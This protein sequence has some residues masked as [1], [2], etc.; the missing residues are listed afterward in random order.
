MKLLDLPGIGSRLRQRL[1]EHYGGEQEA[2]QAVLRGDVA[3][4][5]MVLS[6]RQA[7][8]LVQY[9]RSMKYGVEQSDFLATD[10][11]TRIYQTL[12]TRMAGYAHT[13]YAR[14]KVAALFPTASPQLL[15]ENQK[16]ARNAVEDALRIEGRGM[17]ELLS[18]I[19]PLR[20]KAPT[21]VRERAVATASPDSFQQL[22]ASGLD[23][24]IDLHLAESPRELLD[25]AASYSH[26]SLVGED[27]DCPEGM[28]LARSEEI[29]YLVPEA[30]LAFYKDNQETLQSAVEAAAMLQDAGIESFAGSDELQKLICRLDEQGDDESNR[31]SGLLDR[32]S[33]CVS[34]AASWANQELKTKIESSSITLGGMDLLGFMNRGEGMRELFEV[35]MKGAF[36]EILKR[37]RARAAGESARFQERRRSGW[38]RSSLQRSATLWSWIGGPCALLSRI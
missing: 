29:W 34:E 4:L 17:D 21:R 7:I 14:L 38:M 5:G 36:Q 28:E 2:L 1:I 37:A 24:L 8:S 15:A 18:K 20:E 25:L 30:V 11:A 13:E 10:E 23:K 35:Q 33:G 3:G 6:E 16:M 22:K 32:L 19:K 9:A 27:L 12:I 31:L 26:V